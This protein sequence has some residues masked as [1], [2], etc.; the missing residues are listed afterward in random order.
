MPLLWPMLPYS[1][2]LLKIDLKNIMENLMLKDTKMQSLIFYP[3]RVVP[4]FFM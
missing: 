2:C 3:E 1:D 4:G